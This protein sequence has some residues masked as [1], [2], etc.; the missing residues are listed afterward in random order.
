MSMIEYQWRI[1]QTIFRVPAYL[2][3]AELASWTKIGNF[4]RGGSDKGHYCCLHARLLDTTAG[5]MCLGVFVY[6]IVL[7]LTLK[8]VQNNPSRLYQNGISSA[9]RY[10]HGAWFLAHSEPLRP[11]RRPSGKSR[12]WL[13]VSSS[14]HGG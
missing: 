2:L 1:L 5:T 12:I 6:V 7:R 14:A 8:A 9:A 13:P 3:P 4:A 10:P 11:T